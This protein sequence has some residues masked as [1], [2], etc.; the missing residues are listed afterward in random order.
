M[1]LT[2]FLA[3][4]NVFISLSFS[5]INMSC[6]DLFELVKVDPTSALVSITHELLPYGIWQM[7]GALSLR[8]ETLLKLMHVNKAIVF[9]IKSFESFVEMIL[10]DC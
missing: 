2:N 8:A 6:H 1:F 4:L 3:K 9:G 5:L 7:I 10:A